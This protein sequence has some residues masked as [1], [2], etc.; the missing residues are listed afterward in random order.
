[1]SALLLFA[2]LAVVELG[3][4]GDIDGS[5]CLRWWQE[6]FGFCTGVGLSDGGDRNCV[7]SVLSF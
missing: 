1:M 5:C 6:V 2:V 4:G 7:V 3:G